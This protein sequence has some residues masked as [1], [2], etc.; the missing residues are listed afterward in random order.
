M[1]DRRSAHPELAAYLLDALEADERSEFERHL[2]DCHS[3]RQELRELEGAAELLGRAA[4]PYGAPT[5]LEDRVVAAVKE[6][7]AAEEAAAAAGEP[8]VDG[9]PAR[10]LRRERARGILGGWA[11]RLALAGAAAAVLAAAFLVGDR[12]GDEDLPGTPELEATL[13]APSGDTGQATASVR[14]TGLGRVILFESGDLPIL[15]EGELYELWFV[16]PGDT[17]EDPN[18]ISAGT[19]HPDERGNSDVRLHAAVDPAQ[20][21]ELSVTAEPG[22]GNPERTGPEVLRSAPGE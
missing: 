9:R 5:G 8:A 12:L 15:P 22:D 7:A 16:G 2:T 6:A 3:C 14:E 10:Y 4:P 13:E 20:F 11:P 1:A 17:L 19:F 18:R 21:P